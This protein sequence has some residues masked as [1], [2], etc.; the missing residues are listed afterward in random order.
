MT[1]VSL[2]FS[3]RCHPRGRV[4]LLSAARIQKRAVGILENVQAKGAIA[5]EKDTVSEP[6]LCSWISNRNF[7]KTIIR[8]LR[9]CYGFFSAFFHIFAA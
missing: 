4:L 1:C 2:K 5:I 7:R 9:G 8:W 3:G 6:A